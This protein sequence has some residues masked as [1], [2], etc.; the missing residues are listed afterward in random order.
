MRSHTLHVSKLALR[1][2]F[3]AI[4]TRA[5]DVRRVLNVGYLVFAFAVLWIVAYAVANSWPGLRIPE[6]R[7]TPMG[8]VAGGCS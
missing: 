4:P 5:N 8:D 6:C 1:P 2:D 7:Y 3:I